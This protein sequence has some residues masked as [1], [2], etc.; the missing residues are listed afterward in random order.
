MHKKKRGQEVEGGDSHPLLCSYETHL[1]PLNLTRA[2]YAVFLLTSKNGNAATNNQI[3]CMLLVS[4]VMLMSQFQLF[5]SLN[6]KGRLQRSFLSPEWR[7]AKFTFDLPWSVSGRTNI[8]LT[9]TLV[10]PLFFF[11]YSRYKFNHLLNKLTPI[12]L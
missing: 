11:R 4:I 7:S 5:L 6:W 1:E 10:L 3:H 9:Q 12:F 2:G 8:V